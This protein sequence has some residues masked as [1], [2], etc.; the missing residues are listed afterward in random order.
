MVGSRGRCR[1][2]VFG[3]GAVFACGAVFECGAVSGCDA[4]FGC[5]GHDGWDLPDRL[6]RYAAPVPPG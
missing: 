1:R 4:V 3:C 5:A 2:R 6:R